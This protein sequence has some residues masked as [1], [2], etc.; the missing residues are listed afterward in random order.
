MPSIILHLHNEDPVIGEIDE[1]PAPT[2]AILVVNNP[3]RR[4]GKDVPYLDPDVTTVIWP[5][6]RISF[7]EVLPSEGEEKIVSHV[8]E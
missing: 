4:D 5:V 6:S 8:R 1:L 7:I 2:D 3:R